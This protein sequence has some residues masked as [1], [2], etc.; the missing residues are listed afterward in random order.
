MADNPISCSTI[1]GGSAV[2]IEQ[3]L[4]Y[5]LV[6]RVGSL[7]LTEWISGQVS[8]IIATNKD[9]MIGPSADYKEAALEDLAHKLSES[10]GKL[11]LLWQQ[12]LTAHVEGQRALQPLVQR[13]VIVQNC[14]HGKGTTD[15]TD[16]LLDC[17]AIKDTGK[18]ETTDVMDD[19]GKTHEV[20]LYRFAIGDV[21]G[22]IGTRLHALQSLLDKVYADPVLSAKW[23]AYLERAE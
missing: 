13:E 15:L 23:T 2:T 3:S 17:F 20:M 21:V 1:P 19:L 5:K 22:E 14:S 18:Y 16:A 8:Y 4:L 6:S 12:A 11:G 7:I 9:R 10:K